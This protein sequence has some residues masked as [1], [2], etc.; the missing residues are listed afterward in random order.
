MV[1][2][3]GRE[4]VGAARALVGECDEIGEIVA[5]AEGVVLVPA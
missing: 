3:V 2:V 5:G 1:L 4:R